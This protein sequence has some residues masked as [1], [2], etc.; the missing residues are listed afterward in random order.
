MGAS[1][2]RV[3]VRKNIVSVTVQGENAQKNASV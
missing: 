2:K 1:A 3:I